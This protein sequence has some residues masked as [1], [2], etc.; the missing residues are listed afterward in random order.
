MHNITYHKLCNNNTILQ[1]LRLILTVN[2]LDQQQ[3]QFLTSKITVKLRNNMHSLYI[4]HIIDDCN[5]NIIQYN[6]IIYSN[7][8]QVRLGLYHGLH[9]VQ[10]VNRNG[11]KQRITS[12]IR[13]IRIARV[14]E[15]ELAE[16]MELSEPF[17][18][19]CKLKTMQK[20]YIEEKCVFAKFQ[21]RRFSTTDPQFSFDVVLTVVCFE[22]IS[23][24]SPTAL[25]S[26][27]IKRYYCCAVIIFSRCHVVTDPPQKLYQRVVS[28]F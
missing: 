26:D 8:E 15:I 21:C 1:P 3:L 27:N 6:S 4:S 19:S 14:F 17:Q 28:W 11:V 2:F 18:V 5:Y 13:K 22:I 16:R 20:L 10:W 12:I 9:T 23:H 25:Q 24:N 7:N